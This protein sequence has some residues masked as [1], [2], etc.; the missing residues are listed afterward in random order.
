MKSHHIK[1]L[2][3]SLLALMMVG[4]LLAGCGS[5]HS[6]EVRDKS[7]DRAI[8]I[9]K[10]QTEVYRCKDG[11]QPEDPPRPVCVRAPMVE[12]P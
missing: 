6:L 11:S 7:D 5:V 8:W 1:S 9:V 3:L 10:D 4:G 2:L 12:H